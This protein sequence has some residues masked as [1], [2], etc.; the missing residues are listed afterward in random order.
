MCGNCS[1]TFSMRKIITS[2]QVESSASYCVLKMGFPGFSGC[3][4][5]CPL[6][7]KSSCF[8]RIC[9]KQLS[10][11][12]HEILKPKMTLQLP[13]NATFPLYVN[14]FVM[15]FFF[16]IVVQILL[17]NGRLP[18]APRR[19]FVDFSLKFFSQTT[20]HLRNIFNPP[21]HTTRN[22]GRVL[23]V[24]PIS[25]TFTSASCPAS[26]CRIPA[27]RLPEYSHPPLIFSLN[28][29]VFCYH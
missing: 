6:L 1:K 11:K 8:L 5:G 25:K 2:I 26:S 20:G 16:R 28:E 21:R 23:K 19:L 3:V 18:N 4:C 15:A 24:L 29:N 14:V 12:P 10:K 7:H 13:N 9:A 22:L 27:P 17:S